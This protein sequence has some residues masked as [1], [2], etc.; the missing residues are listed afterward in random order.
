MNV[1]AVFD[2]D[3]GILLSVNF[4]SI[5]FIGIVVKYASSP[6]CTIFSSII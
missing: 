6:S 4:F 5:A 2:M 1:P 3:A